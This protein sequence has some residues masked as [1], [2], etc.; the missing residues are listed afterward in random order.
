MQ[1]P[2]TTLKR[3]KRVDE[4]LFKEST[5]ETQPGQRTKYQAGS[6]PIDY[7]ISRCLINAVK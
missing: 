4:C 2:H 1:S 7:L 5:R 3:Q 6:F